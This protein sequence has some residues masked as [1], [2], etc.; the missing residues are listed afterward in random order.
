MA[1]EWIVPG[2]KTQRDLDRE[3][4]EEVRQQ[5]ETEALA[6]LRESDY[7]II[8]AAEAL[9][10]ERGEITKELVDERIAARAKINT[11]EETVRG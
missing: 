2:G 6:F 9:L 7:R 4:T 8:K 5:E 11:T 1:V 10:L 3:R